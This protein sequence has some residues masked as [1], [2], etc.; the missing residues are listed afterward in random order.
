VCWREYRHEV[1]RNKE[2][3]LGFDERAGL[4]PNL[5]ASQDAQHK[6]L[7]VLD[8]SQGMTFKHF[9]MPRTL[10]FAA[11]FALLIV[12][13]PALSQEKRE[14]CQDYTLPLS[15]RQKE[16]EPPLGAY[17]KA[18][19]IESD[20]GV[21]REERLCSTDTELPV[22]SKFYLFGKLHGI[23]RTANAWL[24]RDLEL[25][26]DA[27]RLRIV[28]TNV[29]FDFQRVL[30]FDAEGRLKDQ[31]KPSDLGTGGILDLYARGELPDA[32]VILW[33]LHYHGEGGDSAFAFANWVLNNRDK[34]LA[35]MRRLDRDVSLELGQLAFLGFGDQPL[36]DGTS[37][38]SRFRE[39]YKSGDS[40]ATDYVI[41][42]L[43]QI[44]G[45]K[46]GVRSPKP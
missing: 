46:A 9:T 33:L 36:K 3:F 38:Q 1:V 35:M 45:T 32:I 31:F 18:F 28:K 10:T 14:D 6:K 11:V 25:Y 19:V 30:Y 20:G 40:E 12:A 26:D 42:T 44:D 43:D 23:F 16:V 41:R 4:D 13:T 7:T 22:T 37:Q 24:G 29:T 15:N 8:S 34:T 17:D 2:Q 27:G 39:L 5:F 21:Y